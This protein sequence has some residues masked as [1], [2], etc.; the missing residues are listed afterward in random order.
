[1][2]LRA[3][4]PGEARVFDG[5]PSPVRFPVIHFL[6][7]PWRTPKPAFTNVM[8]RRL[9]LTFLLAIPLAVCGRAGSGLPPGSPAPAFSLPG[10]DGRIHALEDYAASGVLAVV[11]TSNSCPASQLY[12][13]RIQRLFTEYR[14]RGVAVVA[15]N[16]QK[17]DA[18]RLADLSYTD[19]GET[20]DDMRARAA[21]RRLDYPYLSDAD[22]QAAAR[23]FHVTTVPH[24]FVFDASRRLRYE[25]SLDDSADERSVRSSY[26]RDAIDALLAG[27]A[28]ST[29]HSD[30]TGCPV[31]GLSA[32]APDPDL[33]AFED[34][35]VPLQMAGKDDLKRLRRNGTGKLLLINFWATWCA[36]CASEFPDLES[37][38]RRYRNRGLEFTAVSVNDPAERPAVLE[39]LQ[40]H[41]A[42]HDNRLFATPDVYGLQAAFDPDMP[43]PVPFTLLLAPN[44]DVMYQELGELNVMSLRR[45]ILANL[46]E[47]AT[48]PGHRR[49][50]ATALDART[51]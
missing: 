5:N 2:K 46:P 23:A 26:A 48:Y 47:D 32:H 9:I 1:M 3:R 22:T 39:F 37:T 25:G 43:S 27:R 44:G 16:P 36:P 14:D 10:T 4:I 51:P 13:A 35:P 21:D 20:L 42:A 38:Y 7:L 6:W 30:V 15:I 28:G 31:R 17:P 40:T 8:A 29:R 12:E 45:A 24:V 41:H 18:M 33:A 11:F 34:A 49:Y 50:W 19:R